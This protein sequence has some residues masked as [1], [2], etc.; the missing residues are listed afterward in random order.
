MTKPSGNLAHDQ[1]VGIALAL[2]SAL[3][4]PNVQRGEGSPLFDGLT[5]VPT[6]D[7]VAGPF[8][9]ATDP[10]T[11]FADVMCPTGEYTLER[12]AGGGATAGFLQ[13][14]IKDRK[15]FHAATVPLDFAKPLLAAFRKKVNKYAAAR[16][17]SPLFAV[18]F[19]FDD[20]ISYGGHVFASS[21]FMRALNSEYPVPCGPV[22]EERLMGDENKP[23]YVVEVDWN[24]PLA[25]AMYLRRQVDGRTAQAVLVNQNTRLN[26]SSEHEVVR[27]SRGLVTQTAGAG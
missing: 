5:S 8:A 21:L 13:A 2:L 6:P 3:R 18:I 12:I 16:G 17:E 14:A 27:W 9:G 10:N 26:A 15:S 11:F 24:L 25:F 20:R 4:C 7:L 1:G 23:T 22:I 19:Y